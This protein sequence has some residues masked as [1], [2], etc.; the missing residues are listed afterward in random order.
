ME[1]RRQNLLRHY[2]RTFLERIK[3]TYQNIVRLSCSTTDTDT[4]YPSQLGL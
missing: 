2:F 4:V 3:K 1:E